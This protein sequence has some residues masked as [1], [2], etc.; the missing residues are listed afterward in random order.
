MGN[1]PGKSSEQAQKKA[2]HMDPSISAPPSVVHSA[3]RERWCEPL[4]EAGTPL[5]WLVQIEG[6]TSVEI[7]GA[8]QHL[9]EG[10]QRFFGSVGVSM[11]SGGREEQRSGWVQPAEVVGLLC[12]EGP[13]ARHTGCLPQEEAAGSGR[14][15]EPEARHI[16]CSKPVEVGLTSPEVGVQRTGY[17]QLEVG[18]QAYPAAALS[19]PLE[20]RERQEEQQ[21]QGR[22]LAVDQEHTAHP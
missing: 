16:D 1:P 3:I 21:K 17:L 19:S 18:V 10:T 8:V 4:E 15:E 22:K 13:V 12:F 20:L 9:M 6:Y 14:F 5:G 2:S 7:A 11:S